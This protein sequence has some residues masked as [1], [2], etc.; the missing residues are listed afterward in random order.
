MICKTED[1]FVHLYIRQA[2]KGHTKDVDLG[3]G[4]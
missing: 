2:I 3:N 4:S 1:I